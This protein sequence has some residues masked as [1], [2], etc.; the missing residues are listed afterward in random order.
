MGRSSNVVKAN[1]EVIGV[2]V[3]NNIDDHLG[4]VKE[5]MLDK[6]SGR[7]AY[8]VLE[9]G[10]FLGLGGKLFALPWSSLHYDVTKDCFVVNIDKER[11]QNAPGFDKDNWPDMSDRTWGASV[12]K[13]YGTKPYWEP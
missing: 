5:L 11:F 7:V 2:E 9:C 4:K 10:G 3:I 8:V 1:T 6:V 13:Y 12:A